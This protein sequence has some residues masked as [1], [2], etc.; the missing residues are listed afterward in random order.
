[1]LFRP[2]LIAHNAGPRCALQWVQASNDRALEL[3]DYNVDHNSRK[4]TGSKEL[5]CGRKSRRSLSRGG[6]SKAG[7]CSIR[8]NDVKTAATMAA[9]L[10]VVGATTWALIS[11]ERADAARFE[12]NAEASPGKVLEKSQVF[13][14]SRWRPNRQRFVLAYNFTTATGAIV[15]GTDEVD[16]ATWNRLKR[17]DGIRVYYLPDAPKINHLRLQS[18]AWNDVNW[19]Q[20][21]LVLIVGSMMLGAIILMWRRV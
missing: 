10:L 3:L 6:L 15:D 17:G 11:H 8:S 18:T 12:S 1:M 13:S 2:T 19:A 7:G 21:V 5:C 20:V 9:V 4:R 14:E 16:P